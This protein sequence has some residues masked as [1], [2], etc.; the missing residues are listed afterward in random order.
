MSLLVGKAVNEFF[1][2]P[3]SARTNAHTPTN[4]ATLP[5]QMG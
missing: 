3:K 1:K 4:A 5:A 2:M